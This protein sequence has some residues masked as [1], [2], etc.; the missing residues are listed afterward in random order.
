MW[1]AF[2]YTG[3]PTLTANAAGVNEGGSS[4]PSNVTV[5]SSSVLSPDV[6][7]MMSVATGND[8]TIQHNWSGATEDF[9]LTLP[10][11]S[12]QTS[13]EGSLK[14]A[15]LDGG[16]SVTLSKGDDG[17]INSIGG[18]YIAVDF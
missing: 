15:A 9:T 13:G 11:N 16:A 6:A 2:T 5:N 8:G 12:F 10:D 14:A 18:G 17:N 7:V 1:V 3:S 4:A